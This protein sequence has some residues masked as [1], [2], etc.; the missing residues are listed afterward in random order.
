MMAIALYGLVAFAIIFSGAISGLFLARLLPEHYRHDATRRV[1]QTSMAMVSLLSALVL[2]LLVRPRKT[3][4]TRA[5]E[6]SRG[7]PPI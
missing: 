6:K 5:I 3:N 1:V 4:S 2:G 7:L